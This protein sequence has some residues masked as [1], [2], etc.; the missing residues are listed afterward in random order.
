MA[1]ARKAGSP[2]EL[3]ISFHRPS[4]E[5]NN[6]AIPETE[7]IPSSIPSYNR[8]LTPALL[9]NTSAAWAAAAYLYL[10]IICFG[11]WRPGGHG[12]SQLIRWLLDWVRAKPNRGY[13]QVSGNY[14]SELWLWRVAVGAYTLT[15][16]GSSS[17]VEQMDDSDGNNDEGCREMTKLVEWYTEQLSNPRQAT[18]V[19][20]PET[21]EGVFEKIQWL[22]IPD[23][24]GELVL[25]K[26]WQDSV[27]GSNNH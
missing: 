17:V 27:R 6:E 9:P 3:S 26:T 24:H 7:I 15:V 1:A 22:Q 11:E 14:G 16:A 20:K 25:E 21:V 23:S 10:S 12:N 2:G 5:D 4:N 19:P 8:H 13:A 18:W